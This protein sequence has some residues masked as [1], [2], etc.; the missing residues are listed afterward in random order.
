MRQI[1]K[2]KWQA[3]PACRR[4]SA[5]SP[6]AQHSAQVSQDLLCCG[7]ALSISSLYSELHCWIYLNEVKHHQFP[8]HHHLLV[9]MCKSQAEKADADCNAPP[10]TQQPV[11]TA[12]LWKALVLQATQEIMSTALASALAS[13]PAGR[14]AE[15][16]R[17]VLHQSG[18]RK[19]ISC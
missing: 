15:G 3:T 8:Y 18:K 1:F 11:A 19:G 5:A 14:R 4:P 13:L 2:T 7:Q 12:C 16:Y 9:T 17:G 10:R 6:N